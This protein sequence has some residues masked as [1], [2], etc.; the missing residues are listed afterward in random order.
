M[1]RAVLI[2]DDD[3]AQRH[4]RAHSIFGE[5]AVTVYAVALYNEMSFYAIDPA[6]ML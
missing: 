5:M 6:G 3:G 1:T 2:N 4:W